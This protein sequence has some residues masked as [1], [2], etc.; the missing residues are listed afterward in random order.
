[1]LSLHYCAFV[2]FVYHNSFLLE[3]D[4]A[5]RYTVHV[6]NELALGCDCC[7]IDCAAHCCAIHRA[8]CIARAYECAKA[9]VLIGFLSFVCF[10]GDGEACG[11]GI[12]D[13]AT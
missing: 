7:A 8:C 11:G 4:T 6:A 5:E 10:A 13:C 1:M 3:C 9:H 2:R 12:S